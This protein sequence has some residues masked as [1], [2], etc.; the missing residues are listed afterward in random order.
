MSLEGRTEEKIEIPDTE[1]QTEDDQDGRPDQDDRDQAGKAA[2]A[3]ETV[4]AITGPDKAQAQR[5]VVQDVM[6]AR[7]PRPLDF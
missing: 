2:R 6:I 7:R 3:E 5:Q 4:V 1:K